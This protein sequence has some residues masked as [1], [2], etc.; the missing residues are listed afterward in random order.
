LRSVFGTR[1]CNNAGK[2]DHTAR[3][4]KMVTGW[5]YKATSPTNKRRVPENVVW[6]R[7]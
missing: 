5:A 7:S 3:Q 2:R 6:A 1:N 4:R